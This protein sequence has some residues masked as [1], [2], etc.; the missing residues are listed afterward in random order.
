MIKINKYLFMRLKNE[1]L[2]KNKNNNNNKLDYL[3]IMK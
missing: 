3:P 2:K 1:I